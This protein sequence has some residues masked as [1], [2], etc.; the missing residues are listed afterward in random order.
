MGTSAYFAVYAVEGI[1]EVIEGDDVAELIGTAIDASDLVPEAGDIL[2][3]TSKIVSKAEGRSVLADD[4][5]TAITAE[6][7]RVVATRRH[8]GGV[9][10]IVE[11]RQGIV[12]AAAGVDSSNTPAGTVLL[13]P[14]DPDASARVIATALRSRFGVEVGVVVSDTLGRAW[15]EGQTDAAIGSAGVR[16]LDDLRGGI[17]TFGQ[18]L[19]VTQI[20]VADELAAAGDLIKG[21]ASG[22]PVALVRGLSHYVTPSLQTP[23]RALNR[24]GPGDMFRLGTDEALAEGFEKGRSEG[25]DQAFAEGFVAGRTA[26]LEEAHRSGRPAGSTASPG[27]GAPVS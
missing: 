22:V 7:V 17:D 13:L 8:P 15:R 11:N 6:T 24:T 16:V 1:P 4:R 12:Q 27:D 20:A 5:E 26:G 23:A 21:K 10:R 3:V 18:P 2:V 14:I 25:F 9:T 19:I